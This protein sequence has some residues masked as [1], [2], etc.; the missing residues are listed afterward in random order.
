MYVYRINYVKQLSVLLKWLHTFQSTWF[1]GRLL[2]DMPGN[3]RHKIVW[4]LQLGRDRVLFTRVTNTITAIVNGVRIGVIVAVDGHHEPVLKL[5]AKMSRDYWIARVQIHIIFFRSWWHEPITRMIITSKSC[6]FKIQYKISK[7]KILYGYD[8][9]R[10]YT[11]W[12]KH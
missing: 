10:R 2:N 3:H 9:M 1:Q 4:E 11:K 12:Y 6:T 7:W 8:I 5:S